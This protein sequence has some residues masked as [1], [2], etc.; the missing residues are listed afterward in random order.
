MRIRVLFIV[1]IMVTGSLSAQQIEP[2]KGASSAN[3]AQNRVPFRF[4]YTFAELNGNERINARTFDILTTGRGEMQTSSHLPVAQGGEYNPHGVNQQFSF[5]DVG[6]NF[7]MDVT[8][9]SE[10]DVL[11]HIDAEMTMIVKAEAISTETAKF[12]MPG[13]ITRTVMIKADTAVRLGAPTVIGRIDDVPSSHSYELS[14]TVTR[15]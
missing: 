2:P 7:N 3:L 5:H 14:V 13:V 10:K 15:Q 12:L 9:L 11:L 1:L 8:P 4:Q 6:L